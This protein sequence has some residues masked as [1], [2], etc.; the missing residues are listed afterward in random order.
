MLV[1]P[2]KIILDIDETIL[3]S[4]VSITHSH[5]TITRFCSSTSQIIAG[6]AIL[7]IGFVPADMNENVHVMLGVLL[8]AFKG[9]ICGYISISNIVLYDLYSYLLIYFSGI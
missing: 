8:L 6:L 7:L 3:N 2:E 1:S 5:S 4:H 9:N